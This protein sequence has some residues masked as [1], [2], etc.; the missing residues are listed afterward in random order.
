MSVTFDHIPFG[1][2]RPAAQTAREIEDVIFEDITDNQEPRNADDSGA[3]KA[4]RK[5]VADAAMEF[6]NR[7]TAG[8]TDD[9]AFNLLAILGFVSGANWCDENV[10]SSIDAE[11]FRR[12]VS[13]AAK[14]HGERVVKEANDDFLLA[15]LCSANFFGG[16]CWAYEHPAQ[17]K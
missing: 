4:R 6:A 1:F 8:K 7:K 13:D 17:K 12:R 16:A 11:E 3:A 10:P 15:A 9:P 14:E 2:G 5:Q